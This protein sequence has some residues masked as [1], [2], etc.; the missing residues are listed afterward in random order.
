MPT[1]NDFIVLQ[2]SVN[3]LQLHEV[4]PQVAALLSDGIE[5]ATAKAIELLLAERLPKHVV[6][7]Q[8]TEYYFH[9]DGDTL[10]IYSPK[11]KRLLHLSYDDW[12]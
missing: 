6:M 11:S 9:L 3:A 2:A 5:K 4:H 12:E 10:S 7:N 1:L 8:A